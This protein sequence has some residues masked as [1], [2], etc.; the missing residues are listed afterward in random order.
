MESLNI[1]LDL[2][3]NEIENSRGIFMKDNQRQALRDAY[4]AG[5][6]DGEG[7]ITITRSFTKNIIKNSKIKN[8]RYLPLIRVGMTDGN[9]IHSIQKHFLCGKVYYEGVRKDRPNSK[10]IYRWVITNRFQAIEVL[11]RLKNYLI[12]KN[13]QCK[14]LINFCEEWKTPFNKS[15]GLDPDEILRRE[16]LYLK[17]K[18][19]NSVGAAATTE[20][21]SIRESEV[22][23]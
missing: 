7:T 1:N 15:K 22:T 23:V 3:Y 14:L 17:L 2:L 12:V 20:T 19:L 5:I 11:K 8:P 21:C 13:K 10:P 9:L 18:K 4:Y 6:I 16:D